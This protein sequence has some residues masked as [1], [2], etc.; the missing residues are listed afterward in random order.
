MLC[1]SIPA[2]AQGNSQL[3]LDGIIGSSF[4]GRWMFETEL[5]YQTLLTTTNRWISY[6][7]TPSLE[8]SLGPHWDLVSAIPLS[9]TVQNDTSNTSEG[10][11]MLGARYYFTPFKRVQ[12]RMLVRWEERG[13]R[14]EETRTVAHSNRLRVRAEVALPLDN[15]NWY[16]D[17][18]WYALADVET[19]FT[20]TDDA[21]ERFA[22]RLRARIGAG[23][24]FSYNWRAEFVYTLQRSRNA[25]ADT[26][27]TNES[28]FRLRFKYYF[29]PRSRKLGDGGGTGN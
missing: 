24:K 3:W 27:P 23:R 13:V 22:N 15:I 6:N 19:F 10:R 2:A 11:V 26:D 5:S 12:T 28:I 21:P 25:I 1:V 17:T 8:V 9:Y 18:M 20:A 29:T 7:A 16:T 14:D 4:A